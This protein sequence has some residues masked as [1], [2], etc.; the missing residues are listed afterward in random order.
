ME[1][2]VMKIENISKGQIF[3]SYKELCLEL[4]M[5][6]KTST[7]SKKAQLKDLECYCKFK[8]S[9]HKFII[10]E[11]YDTPKEKIDNRGSNSIYGNLI[12]LL[13]ADLLAQTNGQISISRSKL[14]LS[15]GI[16][17][18][19]YSEC[20]ELVPKLSKYTDI[21]EKFIFDFY[22]T[23][24]SSFK[25]IVETALSSLMDK[26]V[27]MFNKTIKVSEKGNYIPRKATEAELEIIMDIEKNLLNDMGYKQISTIRNSKHWR[28]FRVKAKSQLQEKTNIDF[29]Y[30]AYDI[31][32][33]QTY[34]KDE[35]NE[36]VDLL[37][38]RVKRNE[39]KTELNQIIIANLM[40]S[41]KKRNENGFTS[42]R[43]ATTRLDK[44]YVDHMKQLTDLL[45]DKDHP[46]ILHK[47]RNISIEED[48]FPPELIDEID[49]LF[50]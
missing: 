6:I 19:N 32:V 3:K 41:A 30:T 13:I 29:Y 45:I 47:V 20:R 23:S 22:D 43:K 5:E 40:N 10:E 33:N 15:I 49:K 1:E 8:K 18:T 50:C 31:T 21:D 2:K 14:L 4:E 27:I 44:Y 9:G 37:L 39:S 25:G 35:R 7:N 38:E 28:T 42:G 48:I 36:L 26:R 46:N 34:I 24:N 11:I 16:I 12:Q 17:N